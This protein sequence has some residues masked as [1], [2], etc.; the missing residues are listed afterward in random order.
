MLTKMHFKRAKY[1]YEAYFYNQ[2]INTRDFL[3]FYIISIY[4]NKFFI[5]KIKK[6]CHTR[7]E[8]IGST[9]WQNHISALEWKL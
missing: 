8:L 2:K 9:E 5:P 3:K 1:V 4:T 7:S 6:T